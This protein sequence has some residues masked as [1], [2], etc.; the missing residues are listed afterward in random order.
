[1]KRPL[2]VLLLLLFGFVARAQSPENLGEAINSPHPELNPVIAPD[3]KTLYFSRVGHP[4]NTA[5]IRTSQDVWFAE[6]TESGWTP[7]R[8]MP[9]PV[10]QEEHNVLYSITPDGQTILTH[11]ISREDNL[12]TIRGFSLIRRQGAGWGPPQKLV[13]PGLETMSR[14]EY[15]TACLANDGKTLLMA[16][17]ERRSDKSDLY[18]ST[19]NK[20]GDWSKPVRLDALNTKDDETT[21]FLAADGQTLYFSSDRPGGLGS[22]DIYVAKRLDNSWQK[23]TKPI[24]VGPP[25]NTAE[26]DA[27]YSVSA[28]G[29]Y[30]YLVTYQ[31]GQGKADIVRFKLRSDDAPAAVAPPTVA[32]TTGQPAT[33]SPSPSRPTAPT[34]SNDVVLFSGR[35]LDP[36]GK[37]PANA[38]IVY[39]DLRD[40]AELGTA[41]P[42]P[43]TGAY[44]LVLPYG[45]KYGITALVDG[46]V[47]KS[48]NLDL[49][50]VTDG[51]YLELP[52][53]D[54]A[55]VPLEKGQ[56][57][58]LNN[59]FFD[60]GKADL[61]PE[62]FPELNRLLDLL[63]GRPALVIEIGG[64][65]DDVGSDDS[66]NR[67]SQARA[68][69][70]RTYLLGKGVGAGRISS[71]GYGEGRPVATNDTEEG[72]Q[73]NRRVE[74]TIVQ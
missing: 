51:R 49:S 29:D 26:Y 45:K 20:R 16:F 32:Q 71:R 68:D 63:N 27:Y 73:Q 43:I 14:G 8:R 13:I 25:I 38:R 60:T 23:W 31:G 18:V 53:R 22:N 61:R 37:V 7:A 33:P 41:T 66:N 56:A 50:Q 28:A 74:F 9:A 70:V 67:L 44:K 58:A 21:P 1:M 69:A 35:L 11:G 3:G 40:G 48:Q 12:I 30:A 19:Q 17:S 24:N 2:S 57:I 59:L 55:L 65:T 72:R 4:Q 34:Q 5:K 15:E 6:A 42:D 64:H 36:S 62:S 54:I 10:N 52:G 47:A 39:E 46:F